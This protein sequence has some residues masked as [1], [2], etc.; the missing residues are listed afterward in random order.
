MKKLLTIFFLLYT[1]AATAQSFNNEW[2][3]YSKTYYKF[4]VGTTGLYRIPQTALAA[5]NLGNADVSAFQLWRNGEEVAIYTSN[6][7]GVL[8]AGGFIEFWGEANDGKADQVLYRNP[9]D[10][11][12]NSKSLF[13]DTAA[14]FLTINTAGSNK[15]L[16][17][18]A[19][20]IPAGAVA[21]PYFMHTAAIY[22]NETIHL[23]PYG[24]AVSE[25]AISASFEEGEGWTSNEISENQTRSLT[26]TSLFPF[27]GAGAPQMQVSM[28]VVGNSPNSR[29]VQVKLNNVELWNTTLNGFSYSRLSNNLPVSTL[30]GST[31]N[32]SVANIATVPNNR[33]KIGTFEITYPRSFNL[34]V[35]VIFV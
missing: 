7:T 5:I 22:P 3:D 15:R 1:V 25:A 4:K 30:N 26:Q 33:I 8:A 2:I 34:G 32:I 19:N 17:P 31:E 20:T 24:G 11:I 21:E 23:G 9:L 27:T 18:T 29:T 6:Q 13:T 12:N 10:Q 14:Y 16:V 35:P 28:N